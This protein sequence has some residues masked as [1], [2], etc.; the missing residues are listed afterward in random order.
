MKTKADYDDQL[1]RIQAASDRAF[2]HLRVAVHDAPTPW[3]LLRRGRALMHR[4][5]KV[6]DTYNRLRLEA[7]DN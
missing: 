2:D 7:P 3:P 4:T 1:S 6:I 5:R